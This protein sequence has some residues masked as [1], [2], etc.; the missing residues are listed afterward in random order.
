LK[1]LLISSSVPYNPP[2]C[3]LITSLASGKEWEFKSAWTYFNSPFLRRFP[4]REKRQLNSSCLSIRPSVCLSVCLSACLSVCL[5]VCLL[6]C[7]SVCPS[8]CNNSVPTGRSFIKFHI[9]VFFVNMS[10][11]SGFIKIR[12]EQ[13]VL[14]NKKVPNLWEYCA[15]FFWAWEM[16]KTKF[17]E[18]IKTHILCSITFFF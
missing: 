11:N 1:A 3:S 10:R 7:Q 12:Q 14:H 18:I 13:G 17:V 9:W 6:T 15:E 2:G 4:K 16:F 8:A 5:H